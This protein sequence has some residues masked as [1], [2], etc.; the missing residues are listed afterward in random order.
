MSQPQNCDVDP[1]VI[2]PRITEPRKAAV[3]VIAYRDEAYTDEVARETAPQWAQIH[4]LLPDVDWVLKAPL[5]AKINRLKKEKG[6]IIL[7]HN[8]QLPEIFLGVADFVGDSLELARRAAELRPDEA[9]I[10]V[11]CGVHFMAETVKVLSPERTVIIPDPEAGCSL[12]ESITGADV[13]ALKAAHP[14]A[15]VVVYVNT[16]ADVKA[17]A[18]ATC[19][20][21]NAVNVVEAIAKETGSDKVLFLPDQYL[22]ANVA[23]R[24]GVTIVNW[25]GECMVHE[26]FT[27]AQIREL[28]QRFPG[29][30]VLVHPESKPEVCAEADYVG[31]T[32][33]MIEDARTSGAK[34]I[35]MVTECTMAD[36]VAA[37]VPDVEFLR[38]CV[39]CPHMQK[40]TL[41]KI[42][43]ALET[44]GPTVEVPPETAAGAKRAVER[45]LAISKNLKPRL[46]IAPPNAR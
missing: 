46:W 2:K 30:R 42:L 14:G 34:K 33:G 38:P 1:H 43:R 28:R 3:P 20:S 13:R 32:S 12:S 19:T 11:M 44:L 4:G 37:A 5:V 36:N 45:M 39:L 6:A 41:P 40:I 27:P 21:S 7:A 15:P 17:E 35:V 29:A 9:K 8:Y 18:D 25:K 16:S 26:R 22:A 24:T 23:L 31:S 10:V